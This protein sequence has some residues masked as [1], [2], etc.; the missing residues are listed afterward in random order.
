LRSYPV[1]RRDAAY[2]ALR[3]FLEISK[4]EFYYHLGDYAKAMQVLQRVE[5][6]MLPFLPLI[7]QGYLLF[8]QG[9]VL[10]VQGK[11]KQA[12]PLL[13]QAYGIYR[14]LSMPQFLFSTSN[15]LGVLFYNLGRYDKTERYLREALAVASGMQKPLA[16]AALLNNLGNLAWQK[17]EFDKAEQLL[18]EAFAEVPSPPRAP[19]L[20]ASILDSM[21]RVKWSLNKLDEALSVLDDAVRYAQHNGARPNALVAM[22]TTARVWLRLGHTGEAAG[23]LGALL[24]CDELSHYDREEALSILERIEQP[25][26]GEAW[27][28]GD[29]DALIGRVRQL[30]HRFL[31]AL[32]R[33]AAREYAGVGIRVNSVSPSTTDTPMVRRFAEKWPEWQERQNASFPVTRSGRPHEVAEAVA[34]LCSDS[35]PFIVGHTPLDPFGSVWRDVGAIKNHHIIYSA[36]TEGPSLFVGL[37]DKVLPL[38]FPAEPLTKLINK[39]K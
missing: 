23:L 4:A 17:G 30:N 34:F 31:A 22:V 35:A 9:R 37:D 27:E 18:K 11:Y 19:I 1:S 7:Y 39:L 8:I 29:I 28:C 10:V 5:R 14:H 33:T 36:H 24:E 25:V 12:H 6:R 13:E 21:G 16:V 38:T 26:R 2:F 32:T 20:M 15:A 3:A